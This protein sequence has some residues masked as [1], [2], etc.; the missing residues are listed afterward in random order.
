MPVDLIR[1]STPACSCPNKKILALS[2]AKKPLVV[3]TRLTLFSG[4]KP[5]RFFSVIKFWMD[6]TSLKQC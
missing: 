5:D 1:G 6:E 3:G 4:D 2:T